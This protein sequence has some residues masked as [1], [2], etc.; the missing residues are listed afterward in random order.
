MSSY[1]PASEATVPAVPASNH[2]LQP[3]YNHHH[4]YG[5]FNQFQPQQPQQP[6]N[7]P[8][9][10]PS[11]YSEKNEASKSPSEQPPAAFEA[12]SPASDLARRMNCVNFNSEAAVAASEAALQA[13][14]LAASYD[15]YGHGPHHPKMTSGAGGANG[16]SFYPWMKNYTGKISPQYLSTV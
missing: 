2:Y 8:Q 10:P 16:N 4:Y 14:S 5:Y 12:A 6:P 9:Q 1:Y 15:M 7:Q 13:A 11:D 3:D